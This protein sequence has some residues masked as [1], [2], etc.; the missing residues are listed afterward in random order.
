MPYELH[1]WPMIQGRGE[2]IR[3]ALEESGADFID[4][5]RRDDEAGGIEPML[6]RLSDPGNP[7]PPFAPPFLRDGDVVI[8]QTAAIL[9]YLGPRL[10]LVGEAE[11]DR[12]WTHQLQLTIADA[13][14]EAHDTHHPVGV[15]LWYADQRPEAQR[16]AKG[17]RESRM[18][19]FL[20][21]FE[22]V[23]A[24]NG[25]ERLVGPSL[26]YADLSLF[27]L[28]DGLRY[29]F[30]KASAAALRDAPHVARLHAAVARRPRIAAY[31]ASER[32]IPFNEDGIFRHYPELDA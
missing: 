5:A 27:Q 14:D 6:V 30:P 25:G 7:R 12:I 8:G 22:R 9:I 15:D 19:K 31:L 24:A 21:Y 3:L 26:S 2:F 28:V 29:A 11:R 18:P 13:V 4:V 10:G 23:L 17:F 16:R 1:Y 32:R 20:G